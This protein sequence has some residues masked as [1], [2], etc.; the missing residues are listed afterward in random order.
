M[1]KPRNFVLIKP[2]P[3]ILPAS[4]GLRR[5]PPRR[6][7]DRQADYLKKFDFSTVYYDVF[8]ANGVVT[9]IGPPASNLRNYIKDSMICID[10]AEAS[11][12]LVELD[13]IQVTKFHLDRLGGGLLSLDHEMGNISCEVG[14]DLS[15]IFEGQCVIT[16]KSRNNAISWICD[17]AR[18]YVAN[19]KVTGIVL[20]DNGSTDYAAVD[21]LNA[22]R[23]VPGLQ[24]CA[25][26]EWAYP[27]GSPGGVWAGNKK[28][29]WDSDYC[30]Y[31]A[32]EHA[33]MRLLRNA[34]VVINHDIDELL[35]TSN[36][37]TAEDILRETNAVGIEYKGRWI[38]TVGAPVSGEPRF[39]DF[40]FYDK[41]RSACT[42]K[43]VVDP[44]LAKEATQW[45]LHSVAGIN[46][47]KSDALSHRHFMGIS[48]N[49]KHDRSKL[50]NY[51]PAKHVLDE[52]LAAS[53]GRAFAT[54]AP[55]LHDGSTRSEY[56][57]NGGAV[58]AA[59]ATES[60]VFPAYWCEAR[61]DFGGALC[62]W[63]ISMIAGTEVRNI[64][65][66]SSARSGVA[67]I[68]SSLN[69]LV[70][71]NLTVWG[72]GVTANFTEDDKLN[73]SKYRPEAIRAVRGKLTE[74]ML[75]SLGIDVPAIFGD[76]A[77]LLSRFYNPRIN[78]GGI[79]ICP[80]LRHQEAFCRKEQG[81][82]QVIDTRKSPAD[83]VSEIANATCCIS[84]SLHGL[85]VAQAYG[86]PWVWLHIVD[87]P[88]AE[89]LSFEDFFTVLDREQVVKFDVASSEIASLNYGKLADSAR[90]PRPR[91]R[92][93]SL[94]DVFPLLQQDV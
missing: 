51:S 14:R 53:L 32:M 82:H 18:F 30:Q 46:L 23:D 79:V 94:L 22:L 1:N 67:S 35:V 60:H 25:V 8:E 93:D 12:E 48:N 80:E 10:G 77:L 37:Q 64:Y 5:E 33:R 63:L 61:R 4:F 69:L 72:S 70:N 86:V 84:T 55:T 45:K 3:L 73:F 6:P 27:W 83:V 17:W 29:P 52:E 92:F 57:H 56:S 50:T 21:V 88:D 78:S 34:R 89:D 15:S 11:V 40:R 26:I 9:G 71:K 65:G 36:G 2:S 19:H 75:S 44:L 85:V 24:A 59:V 74:K 68:G 39:F 62:P 42:K 81:R 16:T 91:S 76:P 31:G 41:N 87:L 7:E 49:W 54:P 58:R 28:I 20:Y 13:R 38:E 90:L 47:D 43:W 66:D